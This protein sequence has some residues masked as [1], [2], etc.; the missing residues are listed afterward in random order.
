MSQ[1]VTRLC[2]IMKNTRKEKTE[3]D[4]EEKQTMRRFLVRLRLSAEFPQKVDNHEWIE[5]WATFASTSTDP[6]L[7]GKPG[8]MVVGTNAF[9]VH[10]KHDKLLTSSTPTSAKTMNGF[11]GELHLRVEV[12]KHTITPESQMECRLLGI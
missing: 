1:V 12:Q 9:H 5:E 11:E 10:R 6:E 2:T 8:C 7:N 3:R 4:E